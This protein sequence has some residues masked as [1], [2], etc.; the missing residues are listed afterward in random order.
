MVKDCNEY[1]KECKYFHHEP[2]YTP[3]NYDVF[4]DYNSIPVNI[5][6][7]KPHDFRNRLQKLMPLTKIIHLNMD[8]ETFKEDN[9]IHLHTKLKLNYNT[10]EDSTETRLKLT[11]QWNDLN[12]DETGSVVCKLA[13]LSEEE[14]PVVNAKI[15]LINVHYPLLEY[16]GTTNAD[17][18]VIFHDVHYGSYVQQ[19]LLDGY[20]IPLHLFDVDDEEIENKLL[21]GSSEEITDESVEGEENTHVQLNFYRNGILILSSWFYE[22]GKAMTADEDSFE[23]GILVLD[24]AS[25]E[26]DDSTTI[27]LNTPGFEIVNDFTEFE[28]SILA[29]GIVV[30]TVALNFRNNYTKSSKILPLYD[31]ND[32]LINYSIGYSQENCDVNFEY[33]NVVKYKSN[34]KVLL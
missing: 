8:S 29:N 3:N 19:I 25:D 20:T 15:R 30:D 32:N 14:S 26:Y 33:F 27:L 13:Y 9:N 1:D 24:V 7:E 5:P 17:G 28:V 10:L 21:I 18:E 22:N 4:F 2:Y 11:G 6:V 31:G 12:E 16:S 23:N 34:E